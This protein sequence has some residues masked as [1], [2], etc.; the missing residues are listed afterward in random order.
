MM[1]FGMP[2]MVKHFYNA[3][4]GLV[5]LRTYGNICHEYTECVARKYKDAIVVFDGYGNINSQDMIHHGQLKGKANATMTVAANIVTTMKKDQLL[6]NQKNMQQ[7]IFMLSTN[8]EKSNHKTYHVPVDAD[9]L[10]VQM[11]FNLLPPVKLY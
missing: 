1:A 3:P 6:A 9:V 2:W 8:L 7:F 5:V 4:H 11:L 10:I